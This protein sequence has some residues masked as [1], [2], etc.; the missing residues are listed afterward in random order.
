MTAAGFTVN[1][2]EWWHFDHADWPR[3]P[4]GNTPL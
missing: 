2:S 4:I 3:Y 1:E